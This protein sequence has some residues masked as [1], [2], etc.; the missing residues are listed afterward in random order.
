MNLLKNTRKSANFDIILLFFVNIL[1][2]S[3]LI[4]FCI[5]KIGF[6]GTL[7]GISVSKPENAERVSKKT[8]LF[9]RIP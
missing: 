1:F 9:K 7:L 8:N 6:F 5:K 3:T 4:A 2:F